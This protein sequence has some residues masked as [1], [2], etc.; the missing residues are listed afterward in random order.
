MQH[1]LK[2][3]RATEMTSALHH[4]KKQLF[5][6]DDIVN[7]GQYRSCHCKGVNINS[8]VSM[9]RKLNFIALLNRMFE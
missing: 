2:Q 9:R 1:Y 8:S 4:P 3:Y 5:M 7:T 6:E